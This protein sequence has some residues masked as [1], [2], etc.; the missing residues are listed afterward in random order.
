MILKSCIGNR[1]LGWDLLPP[2]SERFEHEGKSSDDARRLLDQVGHRGSVV[3]ASILAGH[4]GGTDDHHVGACV[5][6]GGRCGV[7]HVSILPKPVRLD[8]PGCPSKLDGW[9]GPRSGMLL[10]MA[11]PTPRRPHRADGPHPDEGLVGVTVRPPTRADAPALL[12]IVHADEVAATGRVVTTRSD[13]EETLSPTV[14]TLVDRS[15]SSAGRIR[16]TETWEAR[17]SSVVMCG[18]RP[19]SERRTIGG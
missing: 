5:W 9:A 14:T 19:A 13:V 16:C 7:G 18:R 6:A 17:A 8:K 12:E 2:G 1:S 3:V 15:A 10:D 11:T 4:R